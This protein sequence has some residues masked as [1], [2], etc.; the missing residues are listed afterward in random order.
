MSNESGASFLLCSLGWRAMEEEN[1][2]ESQRGM[3]E[4]EH[5]GAFLKRSRGVTV[6]NLPPGKCRLMNPFSSL[7]PGAPF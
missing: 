2:G 7:S 1:E 3:S 5:L 4:R 6:K